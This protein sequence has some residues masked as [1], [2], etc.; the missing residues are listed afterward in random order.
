MKRIFCLFLVVLTL[1]ALSAC[2]PEPVETTA[3]L[4][5][6]IY[7]YPET[8]TDVTVKLDYA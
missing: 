3:P 1:L 5:P 8:V 2:T 6:V 4:K 7:L